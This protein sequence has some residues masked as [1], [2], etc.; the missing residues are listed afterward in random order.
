MVSLTVEAFN[1][2]SQTIFKMKWAYYIF[3]MVWIRLYLAL[4]SF[5]KLQRLIN[6]S[7]GFILC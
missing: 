5:F 7:I 2:N 6:I 3:G 1:F 4:Y